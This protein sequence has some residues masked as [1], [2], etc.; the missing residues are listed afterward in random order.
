MVDELNPIH[1]WRD[2]CRCIPTG[3]VRADSRAT[4]RIEFDNGIVYAGVE[5]DA[6][7]TVYRTVTIGSRYIFQE[8]QTTNVPI[9]KHHLPSTE[10]A[11]CSAGQAVPSF[12]HFIASSSTIDTSISYSV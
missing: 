9:R 6:G 1:H 4:E 10:P 5:R 12:H 8:Q 11:K 3:R 2:C 7:Y